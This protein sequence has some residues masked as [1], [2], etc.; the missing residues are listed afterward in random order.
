MTTQKKILHT[1]EMQTILDDYAAGRINT[2]EFI[3][4]IDVAFLGKREG[5]MKRIDFE[6][7]WDEY[8]SVGLLRIT[9]MTG[10]KRGCGVVWVHDRW[11]IESEAAPEFCPPQI[12]YVWGYNKPYDN[13]ALLIK[14]QDAYKEA[15]EVLNA[16]NE[17]HKDKAG[18]TDD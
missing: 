12:L 9:G 15:I 11:V 7:G 6:S 16:F 5:N 1:A 10:I 13:Q 18:D 17:A 8:Y 14:N 4:K 2:K 3:R